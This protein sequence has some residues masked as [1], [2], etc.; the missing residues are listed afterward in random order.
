VDVIE[1]CNEAVEILIEFADVHLV[2]HHFIDIRRTESRV[3]PLKWLTTTFHCHRGQSSQPRLSRERIR[4]PECD[5]SVVSEKKL[6]SIKVS[7]FLA[8]MAGCAFRHEANSCIPQVESRSGLPIH[9][10][11]LRLNATDE[12]V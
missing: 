4:K 7:S 3:S 8:K 6:V 12:L 11:R 5:S 10:V 1:L 9:P 2:D